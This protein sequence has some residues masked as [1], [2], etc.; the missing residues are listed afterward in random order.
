MPWVTSNEF[1]SI[2]RLQTPELP[3]LG[4]IQHFSKPQRRE[5]LVLGFRNER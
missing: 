5:I 4:H 1:G 3:Y 2:E